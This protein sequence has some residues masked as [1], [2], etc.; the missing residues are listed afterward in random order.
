[1]NHDLDVI[2]IGWGKGGKTLAG[3]L[4]RSGQRVAMI[5]ASDQMYGGTCINIGCVPT[6]A[7]IHDAQVRDT[8]GFDPQYF[9][10]AVQRRDKLTAT[11]RQKNFSI[12][13]ELDAVVLFTGQATFTGPKSIRVNTGSEHIDLQAERIIINTGALP[14]IPPID[15]VEVGGRI[16][17]STTLQ[18]A[19]LP[20]NLVIVG[21]GYVGIEFAS[22]FAYFGSRV[23]VLDRGERAL[24]RKIQMLPRSW[25]RL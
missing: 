13:E 1:M 20:Q 24:K 25:F 16:H 14:R 23:T 12:L 5:E 9:E 8:E 7:L 11:L 19:E 17:N 15:G 18:H 2:I 6:K 4:A 22:M 21:G 3:R 10:Q